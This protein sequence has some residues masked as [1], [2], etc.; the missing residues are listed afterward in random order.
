MIFYIFPD[1]FLCFW[2]LVMGL[3]IFVM[4][5]RR[6]SDDAGQLMIFATAQG[7]VIELFFYIILYTVI[8][9]LYFIAIIYFFILRFLSFLLPFYVL[10]LFL[11][12]FA[13]VM[14][15]ILSLLSFFLFLFRVCCGCFQLMICFHI[16][17]F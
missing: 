5:D 1:I 14:F 6:T 9:M 15:Y 3:L 8:L 4:W 12:F 16:S 2:L 7:L 11:F 10:L 13:R 17:F